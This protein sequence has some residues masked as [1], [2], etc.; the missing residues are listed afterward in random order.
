MA[1]FKKNSTWYI[2][3]A[4]GRRKRESVGPSKELAKKV[5]QKRKVQIAENKYLNIKRDERIP[6]S[7]MARLYLEAYSKPN[8]RSWSR[9]EL[10][11]RHLSFFFGNKYLHEITPLDIENYKAERKEKV[12]PATVNRELSCLKHIYVKAMEWGKIMRT[13]SRLSSGCL[14]TLRVPMFS[15]MG[16]AFP[17]ET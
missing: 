16:M 15:V 13:C 3:Y 1:I 11:I 17:T 10:S 9:D 6:F 2:D 7:E 8:K 4:N 14:K 5:L 12:C